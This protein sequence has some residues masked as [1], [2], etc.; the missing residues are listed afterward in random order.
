MEIE[1]QENPRDWWYALVILLI[2]ALMIFW[3]KISKA[4]TVPCDTIPIMWEQVDTIFCRAT[5]SGKTNKLYVVYTYKG[6]KDIT[7]MSAG[8]LEYIQICKEFDIKPKLALR[9]KK[10]NGEIM[11]IIAI[12]KR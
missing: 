9:R 5:A 11:S 12:K 4:A 7:T 10:S 1:Q 8:T 6:T 3:P 2:A